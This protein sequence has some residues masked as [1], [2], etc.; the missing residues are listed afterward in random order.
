MSLIWWALGWD[1]PALPVV[2]RKFGWNYNEVD[3]IL[4]EIEHPYKKLNYCL[5]LDKVQEVDLRTLPSYYPCYDQGE[6]GSCTAQGWIFTYVF[7]MGKHETQQL[8]MSRLAFYYCERKLMGTI[9]SDS[10]ASITTGSKVML[11]DGVCLESLWE[12]D[13]S[14]Y[15]ECP[16]ENCWED[17][18]LHKGVKVERVKKTI[19]DLKQCLVDGNPF[20][21]GFKVYESFMNVGSNGI[22]P[23]PNVHKE[24]LLGG[25]CVACVG[26]KKIDGKDYFIIRNSWGSAWGDNGHCYMEFDFLMEK[27]GVLGLQKMCS[28]FWVIKSVRDLPDPNAITKE[29]TIKNIITQMQTMG[30]TLDDLQH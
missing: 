25:H 17:M 10:G 14:K 26:F 19:N 8:L 28:D 12:Y 6:L 2:N 9:D 3:N 13:I 1:K 11:N 4:S 7:E 22:V 20:V 15:T 18:K 29:E 5:F 16:P 23:M 27:S 30:I 21:F 24:Q